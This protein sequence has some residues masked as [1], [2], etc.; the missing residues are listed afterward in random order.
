MPTTKGAAEEKEEGEAPEAHKR[1]GG[2]GRQ[3]RARQQK[4]KKGIKNA[5]R[6][7][8]KAAPHR[9]DD[10][11]AWADARGMPAKRNAKKAATAAYVTP[12]GRYYHASRECA[13]KRRAR[14]GARALPLDRMDVAEASASRRPC[15]KCCTNNAETGGG[16]HRRRHPGVAGA[17]D[18]RVV[19]GRRSA[20]SKT[21]HVVAAQER[22]HAG[23]KYRW[24]L[25]V[26]EAARRGIVVALDAARAVALMG[27]PCVYCG[28]EPTV[29]ASGLDRVDND[30]G[31]RRSNVAACCWDCNRM[32]GTA[33]AHD[34][35]VACAR[36]SRA[37]GVDDGTVED[38]SGHRDAVATD[39]DASAHAF[40][41]E[42]TRRGAGYARYRH[43]ARRLGLRFAVG[44]ACFDALTTATTCA[45][46]RRPAEPDRPLGLDRIDNALGYTL[47]NIAPCC[48]RC[49]R[50]KGTLDAEAFVRLCAR[51][52]ARWSA[53]VSGSV[54]FNAAIVAGRATTAALHAL[55]GRCALSARRKTPVARSTR[56]SQSAADRLQSKASPA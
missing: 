33:T 47:R 13:S 34:F 4:G 53:H 1:Q 21:A 51:V 37:R 15:A 19:R 2:R 23:P 28:C 27:T 26:R 32:K 20:S 35:V 43:R 29:R 48:P 41:D 36:V 49:N 39:G 16:P 46:C 8:A 38:D 18:S 24:R 50:M 5:G 40:D 25:T 55:R 22:Y 45:Y 54:D 56:R 3:A 12:Y 44:R 42:D 11:A 31:Y 6:Q 10:T 17:A 9:H 52:D 30:V 14:T 7:Q